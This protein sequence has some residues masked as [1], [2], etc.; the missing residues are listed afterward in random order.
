MASQLEIQQANNINAVV[1]RLSNGV[2]R[3]TLT[4][5]FGGSEQ[6]AM[7]FIAIAKTALIQDPNLAKLD[8]G[9]VVKACLKGASFELVPN[10]DQFYIIPY[11]NQAQ[12]QLGYKGL[13]T[14]AGRAGIRV[15]TVLVHDGEEF[16][17]IEGLKQD[18]RHIRNPTLDVNTA[19][20]IG[21]YAVA[22]FQDGHIVFEYMSLSELEKIKNS[23]AA[24]N[25]PAYKNWLGEM[26]RKAVLKR[27][28]KVQAYN[29][30]GYTKI[31]EAVELDNQV[32]A[33]KKQVL[34]NPQTVE[35]I[36]NEINTEEY[37]GEHTQ[38]QQMVTDVQAT[39]ASKKR[40]EL[41]RKFEKILIKHA[42]KKEMEYPELA[43]NI[44]QALNI[45]EF[46]EL[47]EEELE[48]QIA[49]W[50]AAYSQL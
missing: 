1:E 34:G 23:S 38:A 37:K 13:V 15:R 50:E 30:S 29:D 47:N 40:E 21:A 12:F 26:Y 17:I 35:E 20:I 19:K 18:I 31:Q 39:V 41:A 5:L 44:K 10:Q 24:K 22:E 36:A 48:K 32:E 2:N 8:P 43:R 25:S 42:N 33:G 45:E 7:Q 16:Q 4:D 28:L 46:D 9:S 6:K 27:L 14:I 3:Q 49:E 11:G